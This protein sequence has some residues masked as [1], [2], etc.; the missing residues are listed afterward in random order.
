MTER[1][2]ALDSAEYMKLKNA[3]DHKYEASS[4]LTA[5]G[6]KL[7]WMLGDEVPEEIII[8]GGFI[9][10]RLWGHYGQRPNADKYL[11]ASFGDLWRGLFESVLN[12]SNADMMDYL[13]LSNS[14][15]IIQKMYYYLVQLKKIELNRNLPEIEYVDY[16]LINKEFRTQERN[17]KETEKFRKVIEAWSGK[18]IS[19]A[20]LTDSILLCNDYKS[21][22]R[23]FSALRYGKN[24]RITGSEAQTVIAGS[25][26]LD[27]KDAIN[28]ITKLSA[29][30]E[31]WPK[32]ESVKC[33][34]TGSLQETTEVYNL[35][36]DGGLNVVSE[37]KIIG[38][39]YA[40]IDANTDISPI[41]AIADRYHKRFPSSERSLIKDRAANLPKRAA[42]VGAE[43]VV[44]FMN[45]NDESYIW[46]LPRQKIEFDKLGIK[47]LTVENQY[48]PLCNKDGL[49]KTFRD[50]AQ[51]VKKDKDNG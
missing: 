18:K 27:K 26:Y 7:V 14:S 12:D 47:I 2:C 46:D 32:V 49:L 19:E 37:D 31:N 29:E 20:A 22:L 9:P 33:F 44:I 21:A 15:D 51:S 48:Y 4:E 3:F 35:M 40:D 25:F 30:A 43:A 10:V 34:Y 1:D 50:F 8:A 23:K 38:D 11:E 45:H 6:R 42:E 41:G 5:N 13:V 39:R 16:W 28:V 36:R 24:G 17:W